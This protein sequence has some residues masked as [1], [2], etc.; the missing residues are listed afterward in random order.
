MVFFVIFFSIKSTLM[1][2]VSSSQS[3]KTGLAPRKVP[4][5]TVATWVCAGTINSEFLS[6]PLK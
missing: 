3:T 6:K 1:F 4:A 2:P 5:C